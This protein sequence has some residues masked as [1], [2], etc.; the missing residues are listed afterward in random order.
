MQM[1]KVLLKQTRTEI[2]TRNIFM[3]GGVALKTPEWFYCKHTC[4]L[5]GYWE[6]SPSKNSILRSCAL[7]PKM[8][9]LLETFFFF[10][11][12]IVLW[13]N[14]QC[15]RHFFLF[16]M[17]SVSWN[18]RPFKAPRVCSRLVNLV[19]ES[20]LKLMME[21]G[22]KLWTVSIRSE[23]QH[24]YSDEIGFSWD[25]QRRQI[26]ILPTNIIWN[27]LYKLNNYKCGDNAIGPTLF[28]YKISSFI[29]LVQ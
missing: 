12:E 9:S 22:I 24:C 21:Q 13:N 1:Q 10:F 11:F 2:A 5:T 6:G 23:F 17:S 26:I 19:W 28:F 20:Y 4:I 8:L 7:S 15:C 16:W 25:M 29:L 27:F 18:L 14:F 3:L